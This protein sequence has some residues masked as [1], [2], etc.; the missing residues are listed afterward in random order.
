M[1]VHMKSKNK[2]YKTNKFTRLSPEDRDRIRNNRE[3]GKLDRN[4]RRV[5]KDMQELVVSFPI[6]ALQILVG[7]GDE[8]AIREAQRASEKERDRVL[9]EMITHGWWDE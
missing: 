7:M 2:T 3:K 1:R 8:K 4:I 5:P 6:E 9:E